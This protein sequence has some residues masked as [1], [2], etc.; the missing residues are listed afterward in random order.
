M[1]LEHRKQAKEGTQWQ[2]RVRSRLW[3]VNLSAARTLHCLKTE[4]ELVPRHLKEF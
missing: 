3:N 1:M 4:S 2:P